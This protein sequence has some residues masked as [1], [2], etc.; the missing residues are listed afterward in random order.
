M[1]TSSERVPHSESHITTE[2][3]ENSDSLV[4]VNEEVSKPAVKANV[5]QELQPTLESGE[6]LFLKR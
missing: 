2:K 3:R 5:P 4:Q 1:S 6:F